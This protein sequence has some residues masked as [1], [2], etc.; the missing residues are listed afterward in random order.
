MTM[1]K[2]RGS[3]FN[4]F[5]TKSVKMKCKKGGY[6]QFTIKIY[7]PLSRFL[8]FPVQGCKPK[9]VLIPL[10][11]KQRR[12]ERRELKNKML[13]L[14]QKK[15]IERKQVL[16][17]RNASAYGKKIRKLEKKNPDLFKNELFLARK[18]YPRRKKKRIRNRMLDFVLKEGVF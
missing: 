2:F 6:K 11:K 1:K 13:R 3:E 5:T 14:V 17:C 9:P 8:E 7:V 4:A 15:S 10:S 12:K 18:I 16:D